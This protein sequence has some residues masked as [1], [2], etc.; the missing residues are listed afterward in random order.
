MP[1]PTGTRYLLLAALALGACAETPAGPDTP[2]TP[3]FSVEALQAAGPPGS[4]AFHSDRSGNRD[5]WL[6]DTGTGNPVQL[7]SDAAVESFPDISRN[8]KWVVYTSKLGTAPSDIYLV[9]TDGGTPVNLTNTA[10]ASEDWARFSPSGQQVAFHGNASGNNEIWILD[11]RTGALTQ[12]TDYAGADIYPEWSPEGHRLTFRRDNDVWV[13]DL[14]TGEETQLTQVPSRFAQMA[15]WSPNG[16]QIAYMSFQEGYCSV[17]IMNADGGDPVNLTPKD[18]ADAA[19]AWCSRAPSWTRTG[20][21]LFMSSRPATGGD[22]ELFVM[23]PD[24]T[25]L[26]RLT[27]SAGEDGGPTAR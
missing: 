14:R 1:N 20:Q 15:A 26:Q 18:P 10:T 12:V 8:G 7:T 21:I 19:S 3:F 24:G 23:N 6:M 9:S 17:F 25:G 5:I 22:V 27:S 16:Q 11:L 13:T 2:L 4:V